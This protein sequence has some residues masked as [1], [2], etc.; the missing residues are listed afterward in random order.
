MAALVLHRLVAKAV[1]AHDVLAEGIRH[2]CSKGRKKG[3]RVDLSHAG[4]RQNQTVTQPLTEKPLNKFR[5]EI[6]SRFRIPNH[7]VC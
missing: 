4:H 3:E 5:K 6:L 7:F 2:S 1:F